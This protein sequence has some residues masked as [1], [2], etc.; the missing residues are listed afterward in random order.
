LSVDEV[1]LWRSDGEHRTRRLRDDVFSQRTAECACQ[2]LAITHRHRD[3]IDIVIERSLRDLGSKLRFCILH[4]KRHHL[5]VAVSRKSSGIL[6][7]RL[8]IH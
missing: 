4:T 5:T 7:R 6:Q 2:Q 3:E 8:R 1:S